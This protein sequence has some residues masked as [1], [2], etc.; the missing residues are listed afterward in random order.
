M[1]LSK[2]KLSQYHLLPRKLNEL[3]NTKLLAQH[4]VHIKH[5][6]NKALIITPTN[7]IHTHTSP[8]STTL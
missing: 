2:Y 6:V 5:S 1:T 3:R 8:A 4:L 7:L